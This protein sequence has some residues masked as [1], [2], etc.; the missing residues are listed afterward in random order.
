MADKKNGRDFEI[1]LSKI[2]IKE[3]RALRDP[4]QPEDEGDAI[5]AKAAGME[6]D[7]VQELSY[8]D[9]RLLV[10]KFYETAIN[11]SPEKN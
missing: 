6:L 2:T 11:P 10:Q 7:E 9:W 1:D 8:L 4:D 3:Y 5:L